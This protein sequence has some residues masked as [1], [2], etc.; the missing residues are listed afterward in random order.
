MLAGFKVSNVCEEGSW[1]KSG[2]KW[3]I[4]CGSKVNGDEELRTAY[5]CPFCTEDF[6]LLE[7]CCHIDLDHPVE[8]K[9]GVFFFCLSL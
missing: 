5:P 8:A 1:F 3:K 2:I 6:D 7:L 4:G 9:S